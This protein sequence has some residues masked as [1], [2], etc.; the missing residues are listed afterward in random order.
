MKKL[1]L[2]LLLGGLLVLVGAGNGCKD[3]GTIPPPLPVKSPGN[4]PA[5]PDLDQVP[6]DSVGQ[7]LQNLIDNSGVAFEGQGTTQF[8]WHTD[9]GEEEVEGSRLEAKEIE[10]ED[11]AAIDSFFNQYDVSMN[12]ISDGTVVGLLGYEV[13]DEVVC[14]VVKSVSEA[15]LEAMEDNEEMDF[16]DLEDTMTDVVVECGEL[17]SL[18]R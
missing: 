11:V 8:A 15:D 10:S 4:D 16:A 6:D 9:E 3:N 17:S 14:V 13:N 7:I 18:L 12:N 2:V 1:G 5:Y